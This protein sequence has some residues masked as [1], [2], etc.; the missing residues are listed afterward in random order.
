[1]D[2]DNH[3]L[4]AVEFNPFSLAPLERII[5]LTPEQS[6]IFLSSI[7]GDNASAAY[8]LSISFH[9]PEP[10]NLGLL[11]ESLLQLTERHD[12]LRASIG[13]EDMVLCIAQS[14]DVECQC[15]DFSST[16]EPE[17]ELAVL[18]EG[19]TCEPFD[20][21][22]GP[23]I[24]AKYIT[25][26]NHTVFILTMHHII[27]DGWSIDVLTEE[28]SELYNYRLQTIV[29]HPGVDAKKLDLN[30]SLR[31]LPDAYSF[32]E[33]YQWQRSARAQL[34]YQ[35]NLSY[36][37]SQYKDTVPILDLPLSSGK[38]RPA[39]RTYNAAR[40]V[41]SIDN[42][43]ASDVIARVPQMGATL[44]G[45]SYAIYLVLLHRISQ[46][47]D[48]VVGVPSAAQPSIGQPQ[49]VGQCVSMLPLRHRVNSE[50]MF[51]RF[52][53]R[54][55]D[56]L[57]EAQDYNQLTFGDLLSRVAI[58][59]D[60]SRVPMISTVFN[61]DTGR[62][63]R[64][65]GEMDVEYHHNPRCFETFELTVL[66]AKKGNQLSLECHYN[67]DLFDA[68]TIAGWLSQYET[69]MMSA[70]NDEDGLIGELNNVSSSDRASLRKW[71][72]TEM[73]YP[74]QCLHQVI[75]TQAEK[76]PD[77]IAV[78]F[79]GQQYT[80][81]ELNNRANQL[82]NYLL[83]QGVQSGQLIGLCVERSAE[84]MVALLGILKAGA[85]Y[86]P[87]DPEYP[88]DRIA[89]ILGDASAPWLITQQSLL[90]E[91]PDH[92]SGCLCID[93]DWPI[94][95]AYSE[96]APTIV[97]DLES[98]AYAIYT[99]GSTGNP[100]GVQITHRNV[101][102]FL[103]SMQQTP[104]MTPDDRLLAVTTLS[105][106]IH[107]LELYLPLISGAEVHIASRELTMDGEGL[108]HYL[109]QHDVSYLQATPATWRLMSQSGWQGH[110]QLKALIGGEAL[111]G[112]LLPT[113]LTNV[114][115]LWNMYGPTETTV[116]STCCQI[117]DPNGPILIGA[118]IG[119]TQLYVLDTLGR[120]VP[121]GV[122]G[123]LC[124]AGD[125]VTNGYLNREA[126]THEKFVN[127]PFSNKTNALM[128]RTGDLVKFTFDGQLEY[129]NRLDNQ[130]KVRGYRI[131]L[132][133]IET[134]IASHPHIEQAVVVV[135]EDTPGDSRLVAYSVASNAFDDAE[136]LKQYCRKKLPTYML[137]QHFIFLDSIPQ[138][139]NGKVDRK[140]LPKP[141]IARG[142]TT[143]AQ[144]RLPTTQAEIAI[145]D[146]WKNIV[147]IEIVS[148]DDNFFEI[149]GHSL[150]AVR[151]INKINKK[152]DVKLQ[153]Q[154]IAL[155]N[156]EQ[157]ARLIE[158]ESPLLTPANTK[159]SAVNIN[160]EKLAEPFFFN[161]KNYT[162]YGT[163]YPSQL[164]KTINQ[165]LLICAPISY[166]YQCTHRILNLVAEKVAKMGIPVLRFDY[167]GT[168][169]SLGLDYNATTDIWES[170]I[171]AAYEELKQR[172]GALDISVFGV[173]LGA[174]L[175]YQLTDKIAIKK[176]IFWQP[177]LSGV[178]HFDYLKKMHSS[179][180]KDAGRYKK[181]KLEIKNEKGNEYLGFIY[182]QPLCDSLSK[183]VFKSIETADT[184][185]IYNANNRDSSALKSLSG[186]NVSLTE[187]THECEWYDLTRVSDMYTDMGIVNAVQSL[188]NEGSRK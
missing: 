58:T 150:L 80:Y 175:S 159:S 146:L 117:I 77:K 92:D 127:D 158:H 59:R 12:S 169:D 181:V 162:L 135:R 60:P 157:L 35:K 14:I 83:E 105:F 124:I 184:T 136:A 2:L 156:L 187:L 16:N 148:L 178:T 69:L 8:N 120:Q 131:E 168:G 45:F 53:A 149:G 20:L 160:I 65:F 44:F 106:D 89:Y 63:N 85:A 130:V 42:T 34:D 155:D 31:I 170:N 26:P 33:Y 107:V 36:W 11:R 171:L 52:L 154:S 183:F 140:S 179:L 24:R 13:V 68:A 147:D 96:T 29:E 114:K 166:E 122:P 98:L 17:H 4:S 56:Q 121:I 112:D 18:V 50:E 43:I 142:K 95:S 97:Y 176:W 40:V 78:V 167:W 46:Q 48:F 84:M 177:I 70:L 1:M 152:Y 86:L 145:A 32:G 174:N 144:L 138:T 88:A 185:I 67:T 91:M 123:E 163:Y 188:L 62:V 76:V 103:T 143:E 54:V 15:F 41:H 172:S 74:E 75:Q 180:L 153:F 161:D 99:S 186:T 115:E 9:F 64:R 101:V 109:T 102:N 94:V 132:G 49:L 81:S 71:N 182:A 113:L 39:Q 72:Q 47:D 129:F 90:Y 111:P 55:R 21:S 125:G 30:G 87:L 57:Y 23:L 141:N 118:A 27:V 10:P 137:P 37:L 3:T 22:I 82:A 139:P 128:Y 61:I 5:P 173:R 19:E 104:G 7:Q 38:A 151:F 126:L 66:L 73:D 6:E 93:K 164:E 133:E 100:K 116:W 25:L 165:A 108:I 134:S 51:S 79:H 28:L 119:N 110:P